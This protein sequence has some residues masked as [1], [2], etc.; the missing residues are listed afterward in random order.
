MAEYSNVISLDSTPPVLTLYDEVGAVPITVNHTAEFNQKSIKDDK[1][2]NTEYSVKEVKTSNDDSAYKFDYSTE[3]INLKDNDY[4]AVK[5][6]MFT[7]ALEDSN[8]YSRK[9][10]PRDTENTKSPKY[11]K[12]KNIGATKPKGFADDDNK[13]ERTSTKSAT[14]FS[15]I[16]VDDDPMDVLMSSEPDFMPNMYNIYI[17]EVPEKYKDDPASAFRLGTELGTYMGPATASGRD[18]LS[19]PTKDFFSIFGMRTEGI[20]IPNKVLTTADIKVAG[21]L[22]KKIVGKVDTPNKAS[23][24]VDLDQGMFIL[25]AFHRLNGDWWAKEATAYNAIDP[26]FLYGKMPKENKITG[27]EFLL[28]YGTLPFHSKVDGNG[29]KK[30]VIDVVVEYDAAYQI[31]SRYYDKAQDNAT[32]GEIPKVKDTRFLSTAGRTQRYILH[33]CRFLGRSS[34]ISF[35]HGSAEPLKATFPFVFRSVLKINDRGYIY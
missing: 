6:P 30:S 35:S 8:N 22:V 4:D 2:E 3:S 15:K 21:Q 9:E 28:N 18:Y 10:D 26:D 33:D 17:L 14:S 5:S 16:S 27:K 12:V 1:V 29:N 31:W 20:D 34:A 11:D 32:G 13:Y 24:T 23:F 19:T 7:T 25:D